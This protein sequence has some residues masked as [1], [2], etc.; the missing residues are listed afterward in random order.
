M[1]VRRHSP[2]S[3]FASPDLACDRRRDA[4]GPD[5]AGP[6]EMP[7]A[8][9]GPDR[10]L[11][12]PSPRDRPSREDASRGG[13]LRHALQN[14]LLQTGLSQRAAL[15]IGTPDNARAAQP[16]PEPQQPTL[17]EIFPD[18]A[19][20]GAA[21]GF[22]LA[23]LRP[24]RG[25]VLWVQDRLSRREAGIPCL[26]GMPPG[27]QVLSVSVSRA[28]DALRAMEEG[29]RCPALCGVI[30]EIWGDAPALDFTA[31]KRLALRA[32]AHG[33]PLWLIRRAA[34]PDLSAARERWRIGSL[35]ALPV[36]DDM[37]APGAPQWRAELFRA[38]W[39]M[40]GH[41]VARHDPATG[42]LV[43]DHG[44]A[45]AAEARPRRTAGA[46]AGA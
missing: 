20:D 42:G 46:G 41:W 19:V 30:G 2:A 4:T 10:A 36:R 38:R 14:G 25:P 43:L 11:R 22:A 37:R 7:E 35:P 23:H 21:T 6:E 26:A 28:A 33:V 8:G 31:T 27:L 17:A 1:A 44:V 9:A 29:L 34:T 39:R 3:D 15:Q 40:P 5:K 16:L 13:P 24:E 12:D 32:E 18:T 45:M